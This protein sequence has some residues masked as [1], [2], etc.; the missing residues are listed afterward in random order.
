MPIVEVHTFQV[1]CDG[2]NCGEESSES[3]TERQAAKYAEQDG[4]VRI[5]DKWYCVECAADEDE[6]DDE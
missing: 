1:I 6:E 5:D 2:A 3:E 4:F